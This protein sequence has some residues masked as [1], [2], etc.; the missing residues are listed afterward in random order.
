MLVPPDAVAVKVTGL[1]EYTVVADVDID[2]EMGDT[3]ELDGFILIH[4]HPPLM[5]PLPQT[6]IE[7]GILVLPHGLP[8]HWYSPKPGW[9][10]MSVRT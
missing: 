4:A 6:L 2:T 8:P 9:E 5:T 10:F 3:V 1:P 7:N